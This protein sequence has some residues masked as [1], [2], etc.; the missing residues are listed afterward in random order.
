[1]PRKTEQYIINSIIEELDEGTSIATIAK[2]Y[3][4]SEPTVRRIKA[5]YGTAKS[6]P[7]KKVKELISKLPEIKATKQEEKVIKKALKDVKAGRLIPVDPSKPIGEQLAAIK[8]MLLGDVFIKENNAWLYFLITLIKLIQV[9]LLL[10]YVATGMANTALISAAVYAFIP[11]LII[12]AYL[13]ASKNVKHLYVE[14]SDG[15][16][17]NFYLK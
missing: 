4:V 15:K 10:N 7:K 6:Q 14:S 5:K 17:G 2:R 16:T 12:L 13:A 8:Y 3:D 9:V 1:M 11:Q